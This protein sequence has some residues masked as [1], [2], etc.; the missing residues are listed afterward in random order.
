MSHV[1]QEH[2]SLIRRVTSDKTFSAT[3]D[4]VEFLEFLFKHRA[5]KLQAKEI[6][7][8]HYH[9]ESDATNDPSHTRERIFQ[10]R[11]RLRRY[12]LGARGEKWTCKVLNIRRSG[13]QLTFQLAQSQ[14]SAT[15]SFWQPHLAAEKDVVVVTGAHLFFYDST[16]NGA[17]R[18]YDFNDDGNPREVVEKFKAKHQQFAH[19]PMEPLHRSY[20]SSGEVYAFEKLQRWFH[21][22]TGELL[23]RQTSRDLSD[24]KLHGVSPILLGRP[25]T[26]RFIQKIMGSADAERF[27]YRIH[28][29]LGAIRIYNPSERERRDLA[30][31]SLTDDGV[32]GPVPGWRMVFGILTR[33]RNPSGY[34]HLTVVAADFQARVITQIIEA[35]TE[36]KFTS[37]ILTRTGWPLGEDM[38]EEFEMLFAVPLAPGG[39]EGEGHAELIACRL[40]SAAL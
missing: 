14:R 17:I 16:G 36:E 37:Q 38:P 11:K 23:E 3:P 30:R 15:E 34:G 26:N 35:L 32:L 1:D 39:L 28:Q 7:A 40:I 8:L 24:T 20:L 12:F 33:M 5:K 6:E 18:Y 10:V 31:F 21:E 27:G 19:M 25:A 9:R 13:Y 22:R 2:L 4:L 29:P